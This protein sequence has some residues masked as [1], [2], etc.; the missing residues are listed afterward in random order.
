[1]VIY[2]QAGVMG[3]ARS[4]NEAEVLDRAAVVFRNTGYEGTGVEE[5]LQ[6][7]GLHRGSLYQAF[8]SKRGLFIAVLT[9]ALAKP[10]LDDNTLDLVLVAL[11]EL[12]PRDAQVRALAAQWLS[13]LSEPDLACGARLLTRAG[14]MTG[15]INR[16]G[17]T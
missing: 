5:L 2:W 10:D 4:F 1:M 3:R 13:T 8:G 12:A 15:T 11:L 7:V 9:G 17:G 16:Q 14:V 6:A